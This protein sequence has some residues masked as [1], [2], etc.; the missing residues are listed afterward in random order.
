MEKTR[1]LT[2]FE[3][4]MGYGFCIPSNPCDEVAIRLGRPPQ[5]V[6]ATLRTKFPTRFTTTEWDP[7]AA[8]FFLRGSKHYS[9]GYPPPMH[10]IKL[11]CL[12]GLPPDFYGTIHTILTYA[13][14]TQHE[15]EEISEE[16]LV[17]AT[18][19]AILERL[20]EKRE[21]IVKWDEMLVDGP[22]NVKQKFAKI[23]RDGQVG[24]LEEIIGELK[25]H[26]EGEVE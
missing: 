23:Y 3:V 4:L 20:V 1:M 16:E 11:K 2:Q 19:Y 25:E 14:Q 17:E 18:L 8:T 15:G 21:G 7:E 5:P 13:F 24:I 6:H 9:G 22:K 12:R 10:S 26:L